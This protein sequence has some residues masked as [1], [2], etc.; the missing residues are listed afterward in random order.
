[1]GF[2][3]AATTATFAGLTEI[4]QPSLV[5]HDGFQYVGTGFIAITVPLG[6]VFFLKDNGC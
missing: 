1:M 4:S 2:F 3:F 6:S 5:F